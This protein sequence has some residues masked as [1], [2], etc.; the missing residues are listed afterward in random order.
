MPNGSF[1]KV[2]I[3]LEVD[4]RIID[5]VQG[6]RASTNSSRLSLRWACACTRYSEVPLL[7][8]GVG[9]EFFHQIFASVVPYQKLTKSFSGLILQ[10]MQAFKVKLCRSSR[11]STSAY[12]MKRTASTS[13]LLLHWMRRSKMFAHFRYHLRLLEASVG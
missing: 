5:I 6:H 1:S 13:S 12:H 11:L 10:T 9:T 4:N 2:S 8:Q 7:R 3:G